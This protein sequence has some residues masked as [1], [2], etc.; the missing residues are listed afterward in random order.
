MAFFNIGMHLPRGEWTYGSANPGSPRLRVH[1]FMAAIWIS[2]SF[3]I[4]VLALSYFR[5]E[6]EHDRISRW[7]RRLI[8]RAPTN[9]SSSPITDSSS[10]WATLIVNI[11]PWM[12]LVGDRNAKEFLRVSSSWDQFLLMAA[13]PLGLFSILTSSIRLSGYSFL[14]RVVGRESEL[15]SEALAELTPLSVAPATSV[16]STHAVEIASSEQKDRVA[17]I[18]AHIRQSQAVEETLLAFKQLLVTRRPQ[19]DDRD[20]EI[21]LA[22]KDNRMSLEATAELISCLIEKTAMEIEQTHGN[23]TSASLSFRINGISPSQTAPYESRY[24]EISQCL[25]VLV[26]VTFSVVMCGLQI[27]AYLI[28]Q[29]RAAGQA[30]LQTLAMGLVG[31]IGI[32][33]FTFLLL[34]V[35]K[36]ET[37]REPLKLSKVFQNAVWTFSDARHTGHRSFDLPPRRSLVR[38]VP[39]TFTHGQKARRHGLTLIFCLGLVASFV[40]YYLAIRVTE[41]WVALG[42]LTVIWLSAAFRSLVIRNFLVANDRYLP[43][44]IYLQGQEHWLGIFQDNLYNSL[45]ATVD[46]MQL[47]ACDFYSPSSANTYESSQSSSAPSTSS[48]QSYSLIVAKPI[49][50]AIKTWSGCEDVMKVSLEMTKQRC[51]SYKFISDGQEL[52]LSNLRSFRR[53]IR[54]HP[55]IYVPGLIWKADVALDYVMTDQ[56]DFPNLYRDLLKIIHLFSDVRGQIT[57]HAVGNKVLNELS[58]VLCGPVNVPS[59]T[60]HE[61][62]MSLRGLLHALRNESP[63]NEKAYTL[64]QT[65][66]LPTIQLAAMYE[67]FPI[68]PTIS[69]I[70]TLQDDHSDRL[71]LSGAAFLPTLQESFEGLHIWDHFMTEK[72]KTIDDPPSLE[73]RDATSG[74]Y[75][76]HVAETRPPDQLF[77]DTSSKDI[78]ME[79]LGRNRLDPI[80][81]DLYLEESKPYA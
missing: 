5:W 43:P 37:I 12:G 52:N 53:V 69:T 14:R 71:K 29:P 22:L 63:P 25:N 48:I 8:V 40:T 26:S 50:Q 51:R 7:N 46:K 42:N 34:L 39:A 55:M 45:I 2:T 11:A 54:F 76:R 4:V 32:T 1:V 9:G 61:G 58:H 10:V 21:V 13:A 66:L 28:S 62:S 65:V 3:C 36:E 31:C 24:F 41:W 73:P 74:L 79:P 18:C 19:T 27:L 57:R 80:N 60:L 67:S 72:R 17:Y 33:L 15:R 20:S 38:A 30:R 47:Y 78:Q 81:T 16:Y 77:E 44:G 23:I 6:T 35:I 64:E 68:V 56:F 49:R 75:G 70:Q 59:R